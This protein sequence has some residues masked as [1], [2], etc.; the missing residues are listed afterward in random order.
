MSQTNQTQEQPIA[1]ISP[2]TATI[3]TLS[4]IIPTKTQI[5]NIMITQTAQPTT[6][7]QTATTT[8]TATPSYFQDQ[9]IIVQDIVL[10]LLAVFTFI[11]AVYFG[12]KQ[13]LN[14]KLKL[15]EKEQQRIY[16]LAQQIDT[17]ITPQV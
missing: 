5:L 1:P 8:E 2:E 3:I 14:N 16:Q 10:A 9:N 7:F 13:R 6:V 4:I 11:L 15:A 17:T 12:Y